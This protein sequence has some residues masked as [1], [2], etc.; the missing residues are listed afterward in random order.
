VSLLLL[1]GGGAAPAVADPF[2]DLF[3]I[4]RVSLLELDR[5]SIASAGR[6]SILTVENDS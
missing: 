3:Q 4:R 6:T 5:T 2:P 1:F